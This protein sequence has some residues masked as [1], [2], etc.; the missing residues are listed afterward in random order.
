M[1]DEELLDLFS[2]IGKLKN[3]KRAG[4]IRS[5]ISEPESVADHVF[6]TS[7]MAMILGD[8]FGLDTCKLLKLALLHD[9]PEVLTGDITP[10]DKLTTT[11]KRKKEFEAFQ[12]LVKNIPLKDK[13]I[14]LWE[15]FESQQSPEAKLIKNIDKFEMALQA[16]E[17]KRKYPELDLDEFLIDAKERIDND[18]IHKLFELIK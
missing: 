10:Y 2:K 6:R 5:G 9:L 3:T 13:Y 11:E 14:A 7:F 8:V 17:Y 4:W 16:H 12:T 1:N 15:E 18:E